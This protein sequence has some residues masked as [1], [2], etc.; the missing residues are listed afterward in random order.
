VSGFPGFSFDILHQAA[1][2]RARLG[3][4]TTPHGSVATPA[5]VFCA[6]QGASKGALPS[7][8]RD[9]GARYI[10]ANTYHLMLQ[11]GADVVARQGGLVGLNAHSIGIELDNS[12]RLVR[13]G[14]QWKTWTRRPVPDDQ[15]VELTHRNETTQAGWH[16]CSEARIASCLEAAVAL[17][18]VYKFEDILGH[19]DI[20][21]G[22]KVDP[23]PAFPMGSFKARVLGRE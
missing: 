5:F 1:S 3:R 8:A 21:P 14:G 16:T 7:Q 19:E 6:T 18:A 4:L 23:G 12:G 9:R 15:V 17:H 11:P 10:L 20:A 13:E 22:R 2:S